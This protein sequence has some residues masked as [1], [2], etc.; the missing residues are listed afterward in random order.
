MGGGRGGGGEKFC[1]NFFWVEDFAK[2]FHEVD[3][4][5]TQGSGFY[6]KQWLEFFFYKHELHVTN[7]F[8]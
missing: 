4:K 5:Y 1:G 8:M 3:K 7:K 2:D 6:L